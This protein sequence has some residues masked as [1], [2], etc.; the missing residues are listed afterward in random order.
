M[1]G[2]TLQEVSNWL[3]EATD[4]TKSM[5]LAFANSESCTLDDLK[6]RNDKCKS[7]RGWK[8]PISLLNA[9]VLSKLQGRIK[10]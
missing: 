2:F 1:F 7:Y 6:K 8:V 4:C 9:N 3:R 5:S 10:S